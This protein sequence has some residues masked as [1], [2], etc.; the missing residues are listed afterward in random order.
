MFFLYLDAGEGVEPPP[1][2]YETSKLPLLYPATV[3]LFFYN[4]DY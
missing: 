3:S 4:T 2:A 1:L